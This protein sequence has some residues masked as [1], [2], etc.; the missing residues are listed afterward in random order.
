MPGGDSQRCQSG[1]P[2]CSMGGGH[3]TSPDTVGAGEGIAVDRVLGQSLWE[4][5]WD[6]LEMLDELVTN[7][8]NSVCAQRRAGR[9]VGRVSC[10]S[11]CH[12][13]ISA[14]PS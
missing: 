4:A 14:S 10:R 7:A 12:G 9:D 2:D 8:D 5:A 6:R 1:L 11:Q 3:R 13:R